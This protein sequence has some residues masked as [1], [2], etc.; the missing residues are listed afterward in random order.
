MRGALVEECVFQDNLRDGIDTTGGFNDSVVRN[1]IFRRL[2]TSGMDIKSHYESK[3]GRI[4]DLSPE[5]V[6]I[7]IENCLFHDMP[8]AIVLNHARLRAPQ[9]AGQ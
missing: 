9:G 7:L 6:G 3:T 5:N 2:G 8:N 4:E 1:T